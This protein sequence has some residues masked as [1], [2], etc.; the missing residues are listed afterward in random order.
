MGVSSLFQAH[1]GTAVKP[2]KTDFE[3]KNVKIEKK[4]QKFDPPPTS[5]FHCYFKQGLTPVVR[6]VLGLLRSQKMTVR[7]PT[8]PF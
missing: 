7:A 5:E 8:K 6:D 4:S 2:G 1:K 3:G